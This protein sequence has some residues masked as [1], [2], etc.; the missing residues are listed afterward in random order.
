M[1]PPD[2][3][4]ASELRRGYEPSGVR[5]PIRHAAEPGVDAYRNLS[6]ERLPGGVDISR[7]KPPVALDAGV[8]ISVQ[9]KRTKVGALQPAPFRIHLIPHQACAF[10]EPI[11]LVRPPPVDA[12]PKIR[13]VLPPVVRRILRIF[14]RGARVPHASVKVPYL[15][16]DVQRDLESF[17]VQFLDH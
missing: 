5:A 13:D 8:S 16:N 2:V 6:S 7:P 17:A 15:G 12:E 9:S 4:L 14:S 1:E 3:E 11:A 10:C